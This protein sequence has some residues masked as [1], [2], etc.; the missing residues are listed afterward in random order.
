MPWNSLAFVSDFNDSDT[1]TL[2]I[3]PHLDR[4]PTRFESDPKKIQ[5]RRELFWEMFS[6]ELFYVRFIPIGE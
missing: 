6:S 3:P 4:D 1:R 5:R 2:F